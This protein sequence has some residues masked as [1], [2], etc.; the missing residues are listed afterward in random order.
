M[1]KKN[2]R[3]KLS[4]PRT[5]IFGLLTSLIVVA[6]C[7]S[8]HF[9]NAPKVSAFKGGKL[10]APPGMVY[11]P[12]GTIL[13]KSTLDSGNVGKNISLSAFFIDETEVTNKQTSQ[14]VNWVVD[15][16]ALTD[17]LNEEQYSLDIVGEYGHRRI[18]RKRVKRVSPLWRTND[19]STQERLAPMVLMKGASRALNEAVVK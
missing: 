6:A 13:Y 15:S 7:K 11:V 12:S 10:P 3:H 2:L 8:N 16:V 4:K 17:Y 9:Y 5:I 14:F 18:D 19:P 1:N